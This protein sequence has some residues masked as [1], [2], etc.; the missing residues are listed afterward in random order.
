MQDF[1]FIYCIGTMTQGFLV[2]ALIFATPPLL[3]ICVLNFLLVAC[4][5]QCYNKIAYLLQKIGG[6]YERD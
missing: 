3:N 2:P 6:L 1:C 5:K 4:S